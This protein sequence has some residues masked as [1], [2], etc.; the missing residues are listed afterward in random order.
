[1]R[2]KLKEKEYV[3]RVWKPFQ[4]APARI[5]L[6]ARPEEKPVARFSLADGRR[7][8]PKVG[9]WIILMIMSNKKIAQ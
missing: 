3:Q 6:V 8:Q 2:I 9:G 1:M 4:R 5:H 7:S